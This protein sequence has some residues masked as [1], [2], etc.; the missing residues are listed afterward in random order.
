MVIAPVSLIFFSVPVSSCAD[1]TP[2]VANTTRAAAPTQQLTCLIIRLPSFGRF[3]FF[4]E[5]SAG[6]L[7]SILANP[8]ALVA[9]VRHTN[10]KV[11]KRA[12]IPLGGRLTSAVRFGINKNKT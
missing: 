11:E 5:P 2:V 1:A 4:Q 8:A 9:A 3:S 7:S 12:E 6:L 10:E